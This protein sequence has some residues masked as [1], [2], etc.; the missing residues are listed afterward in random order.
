MAMPTSDIKAS[1][2]TSRGV[3]G[4]L[5]GSLLTSALHT[6][7]SEDDGGGVVLAARF[8]RFCHQTVG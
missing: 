1:G 5:F 4:P 3:T 6:L 8:V 2:R 7:E